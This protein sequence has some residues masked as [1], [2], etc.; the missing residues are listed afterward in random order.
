M[1]KATDR[2]PNCK[3][4]F[5]ELLDKPADRDTAMHNVG[6]SLCFNCGKG[7]FEYSVEVGYAYQPFNDDTNYGR[8][9]HCGITGNVKV[10][11]HG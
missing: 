9:C 1:T 3:K 4:Q 11:L 8:C 7:C 2:C 6:R 10:E 5:F